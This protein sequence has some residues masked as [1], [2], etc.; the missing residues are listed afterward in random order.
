MNYGEQYFKLQMLKE[1][2][3]LAMFIILV[4]FFIVLKIGDRH[5]K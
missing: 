4:V 1:Q 3:T 2:V 5:I